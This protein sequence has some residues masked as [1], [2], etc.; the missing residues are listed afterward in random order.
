MFCCLATEMA[1]QESTTVRATVT[2]DADCFL[3]SCIASLI[4]RFDIKEGAF[5]R[6]LKKHA[7]NLYESNII[8]LK[9]ISHCPKEYY[10][11]Y[12]NLILSSYFIDTSLDF[13]LDRDEAIFAMFIGME[14][15]GNFK[16]WFYNEFGRDDAQRFEEYYNLQ[17]QYQLIEKEENIKEYSKLFPDYSN[18]WVK[19]CIFIS[20][21]IAFAYRGYTKFSADIV[22]KI[23][24]LYFNTLLQIDDYMDIDIDLKTKNL[25]PLH[26]S[27]FNETGKIARSKSDLLPYI[28]EIK[29]EEWLPAEYQRNLK[30]MLRKLHR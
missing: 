6:Q 29:I 1:A 3:N 23:Y 9:S 12:F 22:L 21:I 18:Y 20:P 25:T 26:S 10:S 11:N 7:S 5:L 19:Q 13:F 28:E 27:Y 15:Y 24:K 4:D 14:L 17:L 2:M 8:T 16:V 30:I